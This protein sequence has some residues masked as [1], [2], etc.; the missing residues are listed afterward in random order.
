MNISNRFAVV[1][2]VLAA[3]VAGYLVGPPLVQA[4]TS[5]VTIQGAGSTNRAKV[6]SSGRLR[7]DTEAG[8]DRG[9]LSVLPR[10]G[11]TSTTGSSVFTA[12]FGLPVVLASGT[13][14]GTDLGGDSG[15][16]TTVV[17]G[18]VGTT[19]TA[20]TN[21]DG[22]PGDLAWQNSG[23]GHFSDTFEGGIFYCGPLNVVLQG[24]P[25]GHPWLLYGY[26]LGPASPAVRARRLLAKAHPGA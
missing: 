21:C 19:V 1:G 16:L 17:A 4:A 22:N 14:N 5:L 12:P 11:F 20:D 18:D 6:T 8:V 13:T 25:T 26:K 2:M 24:G 15:V 7:V 9:R 23:T 10:G 3:G